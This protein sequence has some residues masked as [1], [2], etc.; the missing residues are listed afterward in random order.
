M[1]R[2][3]I[4]TL[5]PLRTHDAIT[6][7]PSATSVMP[8]TLSMTSPTDSG[9]R[10]DATTTAV[11]IANA[12]AAC[13]NVYKVASSIERRRLCCDA[14]MSLRAARW[15]QSNP[16]RNPSAVAVNT[17]PISRPVLATIT[18]LPQGDASGLVASGGSAAS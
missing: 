11:P 4:R 15:S 1:P 9:R 12:T 13:P 5:R 16:C 3:G 2:L 8:T 7:T 6:K 17:K 18:L 10:A 14:A